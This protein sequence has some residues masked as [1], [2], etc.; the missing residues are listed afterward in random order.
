MSSVPDVDYRATSKR[1]TWTSLPAAVRAEVSRLAG[2][3]VVRADP[4]VTSGFTGSYAG[5]VRCADG[6]RVFVKAGG[7]DMPFVVSALAR[8]GVVLRML[9]PGIPAPRLIGAG[10]SDGWSVI[11]LGVIDGRMPGQPWTSGDV[12]AVHRA[13]L[14]VAELTTP[15]PDGM[16]WQS[17]A[18][19][20]AG[21]EKILA[22]G[23]A[24]VQ[25]RFGPPL[26]MPQWLRARQPEIA[27]LILEAG[28]HPDG[29]TLSHGD[30]R[31]DNLLVDAAGKAWVVDWNWVGV[32]PAWL[33]LV[34]MLPMMRWHGLD[35]DE[36]VA[37]SSL[38]RGADRDGIDGF[39][40]VIAAYMMSGLDEA[41]P[42]GCTPA[43][44]RHQRLMAHLFLELLRHR[45][46]WP[47]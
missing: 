4:V 13:C 14:T 28:D 43:L 33:D 9:P 38:T 20:M 6:S 18:A 3:P 42:P 16:R 30:I 27:A 8:E 11:V 2:S 5:S 12:E 26:G 32:G 1:P 37:T 17:V 25:G 24:M 35:V 22:V 40:A 46:D 44:R 15:C 23:R 39:L 19:S 7:P 36:L 34:G 10:E 47:P 29:D 41:P 45:R 21:D 31:P